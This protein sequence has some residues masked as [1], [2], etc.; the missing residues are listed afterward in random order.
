MNFKIISLETL[1][2][3]EIECYYADNVVILGPVDKVG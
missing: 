1:C 2:K 3:M